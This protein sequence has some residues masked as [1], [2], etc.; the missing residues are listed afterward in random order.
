MRYLPL[1]LL[2]VFTI[3]NSVWF[4]YKAKQSG[5]TKQ[6]KIL[7]SILGGAIFIAIFF[8]FN[9]WLDKKKNMPHWFYRFI[10]EYGD[11]AGFCLVLIFVFLISFIIG[12]LIIRKSNTNE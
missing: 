6:A 1:I 8:S 7:Y 3:I 9:N 12:A 10:M 5:K 4:F 2:I 11:P